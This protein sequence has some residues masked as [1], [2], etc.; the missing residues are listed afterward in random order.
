M[1]Q[2]YPHWPSLTKAVQ[3]KSWGD[4]RMSSGPTSKLQ[5]LT[6]PLPQPRVS[7]IVISSPN[8]LE[9]LKKNCSEIYLLFFYLKISDSNCIGVTGLGIFNT[10]T[11]SKKE[12]ICLSILFFFLR[13]LN[14]WIQIQRKIWGR[15][16]L[17]MSIA[18]NRLSVDP[19]TMCSQGDSMNNS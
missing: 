11:G 13:I 8:P 15:T 2:Q 16:Y 4:P 12:W 3:L 17:E 1:V 19:G 9:Q 6:T 10:W 5:T 18:C 14:T 7:R